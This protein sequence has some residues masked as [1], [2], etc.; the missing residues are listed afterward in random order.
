[1][2]VRHVLQRR[3]C[4]RLGPGDCAIGDQL[5]L[6]PEGGDHTI[7]DAAGPFRLLRPLGP[8]N[9]HLRARPLHTA[10]ATFR[11]LR[12]S[13]L[14]IYAAPGHGLPA[15]DA[16][17]IDAAAAIEFR[18]GGR[19][20]RLPADRRLVFGSGV[21]GEQRFL[22]RLALE[23]PDAEADHQRHR[24]ADQDGW[25]QREFHPE[26]PSPASFL[27]S[28]HSIAALLPRSARM[29]AAVARGTHRMMC[30][31]KGGEKLS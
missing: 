6:L 14:P 2:V 13:R 19:Q 10:G 17:A 20:A 4:Q 25:N 3:W 21:A 15:D 16:D 1:M 12:E 26:R 23:L 27:Y 28:S 9:S 24:G 11:D 18:L 30:T 31:Q 5:D 7:D 22:F 29:V 8:A